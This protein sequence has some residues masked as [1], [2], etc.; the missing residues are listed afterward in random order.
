M[1]QYYGMKKL[2]DE[3]AERVESILTHIH[4]RGATEHLRVS[5]HSGIEV[6]QAVVDGVLDSIEELELSKSAPGDQDKNDLRKIK[7]SE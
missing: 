6:I 3:H 5:I 7:I 2:L 4:K 1:Y